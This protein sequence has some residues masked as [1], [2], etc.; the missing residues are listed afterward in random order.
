MTKADIKRA[1]ENMAFEFA[2]ITGSCPYDLY[3]YEFKKCNNCDM[4]TKQCFI[5]YFM[6]ENKE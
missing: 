6:K 4:N 1:L 2:E 3:D 5:D